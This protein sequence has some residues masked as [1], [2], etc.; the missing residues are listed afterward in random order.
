M[1]VLFL[2]RGELTPRGIFSNLPESLCQVGSRGAP[3]ALGIGPGKAWRSNNGKFNVLLLP[4]TLALAPLLLDIFF[5][6]LLS[7][8]LEMRR[9]ELW[10][11]KGF[12]PSSPRS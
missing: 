2:L 1:F 3:G 11:V 4:G 10:E 5:L 8:H 7:C 6:V 12:A 9:L